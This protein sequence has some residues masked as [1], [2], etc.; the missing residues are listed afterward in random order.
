MDHVMACFAA[1]R[2]TATRVAAARRGFARDPQDLDSL[3]ILLGAT[4]G[5]ER[6]AWAVQAAVHHPEVWLLG[7]SRVPRSSP[8]H[9]LAREVWLRQTTGV[10][11]ARPFFNAARFV[12]AEDR[13]EGLRLAQAVVDDAMGEDMATEAAR[14]LGECRVAAAASGDVSLARRAG[15]LGLHASLVAVTRRGSCSDGEVFELRQLAVS[16]RLTGLGSRL[17]SLASAEHGEALNE[18]VRSI[19]ADVASSAT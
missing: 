15:R 12:S 11:R 9:G 14:F 17:Q 8:R 2:A 16:A 5:E 13:G 1:A 18:A 4:Q 10:L 3:L 19:L 7:F 6:Y